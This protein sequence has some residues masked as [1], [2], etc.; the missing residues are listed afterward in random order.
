[1]VANQSLQENYREDGGRHTQRGG[2]ICCF[3]DI[4]TLGGS[5]FGQPDLPLKLSGLCLT[6][7][8]YLQISLPTSL[9]YDSDDLSIFPLKLM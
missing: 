4:Q 7:V 8:Q 6:L 1:M 5:C 9:F 3:G 2:G